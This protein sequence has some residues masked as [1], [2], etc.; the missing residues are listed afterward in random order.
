VGVN[1][2]LVGVNCVLVGVNCVLVCVDVK[3]ATDGNWLKLFKD[4]AMFPQVGMNCVLVGVKCV[5]VVGVFL[6]ELCELCVCVCGSTGV[7]VRSQDKGRRGRIED[8][9]LPTAEDVSRRKIK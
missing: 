2:V 7:C 4:E 9:A 5:L 1:C 6:C 8:G 3:A